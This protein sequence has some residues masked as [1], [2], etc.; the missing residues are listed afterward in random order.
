MESNTFLSTSSIPNKLFIHLWRYGIYWIS[1]KQ[2]LVVVSS[3]HAQIAIHEAS[4][5]CVWLRKFTQHIR[6]NGVITFNRDVPTI[7]Y[8]D[9]A[10]CITQNE[11]RVYQKRQHQTYITKFF[12]T[13]KECGIN[14]QNIQSYNNLDNLF[15]KLL[16][17]SKFEKMVWNI[18]MRRFKEINDVS[19]RGSWKHIVLFSL[20]MFF[21]LGFLS[22]V[23][24]E[25]IVFN[26]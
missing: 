3:N 23:F 11:G 9:S 17:T 2:T 15:T 22:N 20:A 4:C 1:I 10:A 12:F 5:T 26:V 6:E 24:N 21:P 13:Q 14:I 7:L 25:A 18:G 8:E 16:P 19:I